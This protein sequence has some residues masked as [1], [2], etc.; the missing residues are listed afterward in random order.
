MSLNG[1]KNIQKLP[2]TFTKAYDFENKV[3]DK[4]G[5]G[6][7]CDKQIKTITIHPIVSNA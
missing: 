2:K 3:I 5:Q 7:R 6:F 1:K 4:E